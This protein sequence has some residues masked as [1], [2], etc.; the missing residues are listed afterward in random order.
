MFSVKAVL[1]T[2]ATALLA[3]ARPTVDWTANAP[4]GYGLIS[5]NSGSPVH[6]ETVI[7]KDNKVYLGS[8]S[9]ATAS[10]NGNIALYT[11]TTHG[12]AIYNFIESEKNTA[13]LTIHDDGHLEYQF[14]D[15]SGAV[16]GEY[17]GWNWT[18]SSAPHL[19]YNGVEGA[20][21]CLGSTG[22]AQLYFQTGDNSVTC[23]SGETAYGVSLRRV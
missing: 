7:L 11:E 12:F 2:A 10:L 19:A 22:D 3:S 17:S 21:A 23:P 14:W 9:N 18:D 1:A 4:T 15:G 5:I 13:W 6:L 8:G 20:I 16:V